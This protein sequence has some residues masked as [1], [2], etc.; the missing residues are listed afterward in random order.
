MGVNSGSVSEE[1]LARF[2]GA[3]PEALVESALDEV[4]VL[5]RCGFEDIVIA[6]SVSD[7]PRTIT[8]GCSR[9]AL[10]LPCTSG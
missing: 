8:R 1:V 9:R 7:A 4:Q 3:T 10:R 5:E 2:G 6:I